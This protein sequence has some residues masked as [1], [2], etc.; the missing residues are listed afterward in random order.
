MAK[1]TKRTLSTHRRRR[2]VAKAS[3]TRLS[4]RLKDLEADVSQPATID[5][6]QR[7]QQKLDTLDVD[8]RAHHHNVV[9]L[10]D[11]ER[12]HWPENKTY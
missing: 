10:T 4:T 1:E 8:F 7:M 5:H 9:D 2:D 11:S 3:I 12:I 6:T